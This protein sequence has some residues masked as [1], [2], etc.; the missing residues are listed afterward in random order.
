MFASKFTCN[1]K[2]VND[3]HISNVFAETERFN[4][5]RVIF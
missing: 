2:S 5:F 1:V 3:L 4:L